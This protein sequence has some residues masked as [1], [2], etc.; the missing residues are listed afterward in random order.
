MPV[1]FRRI[2]EYFL[3]LELT[4]PAERLRSSFLGV[5]NRVPIPHRIVPG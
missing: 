4:E 5:L 2:D 1:L 3:R